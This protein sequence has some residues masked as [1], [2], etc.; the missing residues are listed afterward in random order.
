M[1]DENSGTISAFEFFEKFPNEQ[2]AIDFLE[3]ERWPD[4]AACP[5]CDSGRTKKI[6]TSNR[7][8]CNGCRKQFTVRT[9]SIFERSH[10]PLHK[11]L[12]AMYLMQTARKGIS[13]VQLSKELGIT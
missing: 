12:Y 9:G 2:A 7:H 8:Q 13:S 11:W 1:A 3:A 6:G 10:I 5:R 4:G